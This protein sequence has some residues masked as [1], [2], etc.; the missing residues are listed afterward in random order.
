VILAEIDPHY[1][2]VQ[3]TGEAGEAMQSGAN[4]RRKTLDGKALIK[5]ISWQ[6]W[7]EHD[8]QAYK[9]LLLKA[10]SIPKTSSGKTQR[11]ACRAEFLAGRLESWHE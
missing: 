6:V 2:T 9:V 7:E 5:D 10:G 4:T 11:R 3:Q 8:L 1:Q